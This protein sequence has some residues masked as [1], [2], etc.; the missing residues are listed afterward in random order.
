M[1]FPFIIIGGVV[2]AYY[3]WK[4]YNQPGSVRPV[5]ASGGV[6]YGRRGRKCLSC[7]YEGAMK[8]WLANYNAPQFIAFICLLFWVIPGLIF[9]AVFWGKYK[10]PNCGALGKNRPLS[11]PAPAQKIEIVPDE[12]KCPFCAENI[13]IAAIVCRY[14]GRDIPAPIT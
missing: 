14:C 12:K 13:K 11:S 8:T 1:L 5:Q 4:E 6:D 7:G 10:C 9:I 3:A 2:V